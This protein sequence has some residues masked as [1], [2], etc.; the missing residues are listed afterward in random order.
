V[1]IYLTGFDGMLGNDVCPELEAAG[2][3]LAGLDFV[4]ITDARAIGDDLRA[5]RPEW[6]LHLA[7]WT[8]VDGAESD[9][10]GARRVNVD[11]TRHVAAAAREAGAR[12]LVVST[13][14]VYDGT[15]QEPYVEDDPVAPLGVYGRTKHEA[16]EAARALCPEVL[17]VRTAWL[18][19]PPAPRGGGNFVDT[20]LRLAAERDR[21]EVVADQVGC[22]THTADLARALRALVER[23]ASGIVH[24]VGSGRTSWHGFAREI[25]RQAGEDPT[26]IVE[27]TTARFARPAP[28]PARSV[29]ST[30]RL[31]ALTGLRMQR[32]QDALADYLER[33]GRLA[34]GRT[35]GE[36]P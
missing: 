19:G 36:R 21:I 34:A 2:H 11:G 6:V 31:E 29:L 30:A 14:Y 35:A 8:H 1:R 10:D 24:A 27:T 17:V 23:G 22:P 18:Y 15:K 5:A 25:L 12:L 16:E 3:A 7:A 9:P 13:D 28:R 33:R 26:K 32:W 20:M 4:D